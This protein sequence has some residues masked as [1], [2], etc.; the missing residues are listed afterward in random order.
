MRAILLA[1]G[2]GARLSPLTDDR[3]KCMVPFCGRP[4]FEWQL[5][6]LRQAGIT[7]IHVVTGYRADAL[8]PYV[9]T[10]WHNPDWDSTNMIASLMAARSVL[11]DG[12]DDV[13]VAYTDLVYEPR[14]I[15]AL[16]ERPEALVLKIDLR[17]KE[18]WKLRMENPYDD[19]E[20]LTYDGK[21]CVTGLGLKIASPSDVQGQ[22]MGLL[23]LSPD[24]ARKLT[25]FWDDAPE[26]PN[27]ALGKHKKNAYMTDIL[28]GMI[29][30]GEEVFADFTQAGWFEVDTCKDLEKY[31]AAVVD[32]QMAGLISLEWNTVK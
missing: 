1:A 32:G 18:L 2:R 8:A 16:T 30:A 27:W 7:D 28:R 22:Y 31:E 25:A 3:P 9:V 17:W 20:T 4:L 26:M 13:I 5:A 24:G 14:L 10:C 12:A 21:G 23:K 19:A 11:E 29:E 6:A 15:S